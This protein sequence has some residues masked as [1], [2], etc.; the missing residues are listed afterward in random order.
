M[1][2]NDPIFM[3]GDKVF[4]NGEKFKQEL[5]REGKSLTGWIHAPV[6]NE[7]GAYVVWLPETKEQDSYILSARSLTHYRP[8][9]TEKHAGGPEVQIQPRRRKQG[10][11]E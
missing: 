7:E 5:T 8:A 10:D 11:Q 1:S 6:Q 2:N 4:Y 9:K 3:P